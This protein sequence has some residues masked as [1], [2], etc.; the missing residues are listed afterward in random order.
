VWRIVLLISVVALGAAAFVSFVILRQKGEAASA[1]S[2]SRERATAVRTAP[3][4]RQTILLRATYRGELSAEVAELSA[5]AT[6]RLDEVRV[7]IGDSFEKGDILAVID[8]TQTKRQINEAQAQV[9]AA[10]AAERRAGAEKAAAKIDLDRGL[11]LLAEHL[12]AEQEVDTMKA[13]I[14]VA[15]ADADTAAA[16]SA[17]A[18]AR[19][20]LLREQLKETKLVAPFDGAVAERHLDPGALVQPGARVLRLVR[21]GALRVRFRVPES[22][23]GRIRAGVSFELKTQA[24]GDQGFSGKVS[25]MAA[26][27][28]RLDRSLLVEGVL[29]AEHDVLRPGMYA[30]VLLAFGQLEGVL[31]V[32]SAAVASEITPTGEERVGVYVVS[33]GK[34]HFKQVRVLGQSGDDTAIEGV[35]LGASVITLGHDYLRDGAAVEVAGGAAK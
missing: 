34:A 23:L 4:K 21:S 12:V 26:E 35:A 13:R 2:P 24:T 9:Q 17:E 33:D 19:V 29:D 11:K 15:S 32:P 25:Q 3:V 8:A 6:G 14:D 20:A 10:R 18:E 22:D 27:V 1:A 5:Q 16:R 31:T 28:S 30:E 7:T